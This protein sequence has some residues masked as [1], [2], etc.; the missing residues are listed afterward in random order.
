MAKPQ[1]GKALGRP[2]IASTW[3]ASTAPQLSFLLDQK[4]IVRKTCDR[5]LVQSKT[6]NA[7]G[8]ILVALQGAAWLRLHTLM[9]PR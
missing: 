3:T 7:A 1:K 9:R 4:E 8:F 5:A 2:I 6:S